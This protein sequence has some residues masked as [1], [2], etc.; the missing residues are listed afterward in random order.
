MVNCQCNRQTKYLC[1]YLTLVTF[2]SNH[3]GLD[4]GIF[5]FI[6]RHRLGQP[7]LSASPVGVFVLI[8][9]HLLGIL[10]C[11]TPRTALVAAG[12]NERRT[13]PTTRPLN[14]QT[15]HLEGVGFHISLSMHTIMNKGH[16]PVS[17]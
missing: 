8:R 5:L 3:L 7:L 17:H 15:A 16:I 6:Y 1:G 12:K 2:L 14:P 11:D 4:C 13:L 9:R 10:V